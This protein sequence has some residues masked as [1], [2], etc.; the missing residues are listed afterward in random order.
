[1]VASAENLPPIEDIFNPNSQEYME[2]PITQ[3]LELAKRGRLVW[4]E[5]WQAW[6]ITRLDDI[7]ACWKTEPLA[8]DFYAGS[9]THLT[10]PTTHS[11]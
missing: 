11:E 10:L 1:M 2:N 3:C 6:I 7:M 9:Y 8:S 4:Y 5:P